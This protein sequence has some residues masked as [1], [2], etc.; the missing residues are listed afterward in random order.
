MITIRGF[1][2]SKCLPRHVR[3]QNC[4]DVQ[5]G[6]LAGLEGGEEAGLAACP[7]PDDDELVAT[8][9]GR[10]SSVFLLWFVVLV[11]TLVRPGSVLKRSIRFGGL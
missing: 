11:W 4:W 8:H 6:K 7:V 9:T 5:S 2:C 1:H 10:G 3:F